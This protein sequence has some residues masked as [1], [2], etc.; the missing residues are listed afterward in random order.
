MTIGLKSPVVWGCFIGITA[1]AGPPQTRRTACAYVM[2]RKTGWVRA[3]MAHLAGTSRSGGGKFFSGF[4]R[5]I[6]EIAYGAGRWRKRASRLPK[7]SG[8]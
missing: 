7:T 5:N 2:A 4:P 3:T 1:D 8:L 6:M